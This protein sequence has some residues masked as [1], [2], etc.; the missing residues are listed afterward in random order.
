[1]RTP[2]QFI[3]E[4]YAIEQDKPIV[5]LLLDHK[6]LLYKEGA[7]LYIAFGTNKNNKQF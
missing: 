3:K 6:G 2:I 5:A 1:M 7:T 4:T